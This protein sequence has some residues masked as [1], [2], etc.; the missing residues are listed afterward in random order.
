MG[1]LIDPHEVPKIEE[2][3]NDS[4]ATYHLQ[5]NLIL[6][7]QSGLSVRQVAA[8]VGISPSGVQY[9]VNRY[10]RLRL[11]AFIDSKLETNDKEITLVDE[12]N[13]IQPE[14]KT[15]NTPE[16]KRRPS[17]TKS[18]A[19]QEIRAKKQELVLPKKLDNPGLKPG[20]TMA[21]AGKKTLLYHFLQMLNNEKGT[22]LGDDIEALHDMRVATRRMRAAFDVFEKEYDQKIIRSII[23]GLRQT[24]RAL[25]EVRDLD[26]FIEKAEKYLSAQPEDKMLG[27]DPLLKY[28]HDQR[29]LC[30][31]KM[32]QYLESTA[33]RNF[34]LEFTEFL[35]TEGL[36]IKDGDPKKKFSKNDPIPIPC[37]VQYQVPLL[38]YT[39][40][41]H[42]NAYEDL[43]QNAIITQLHALR[44]E[45]KRLR[46]SL[47]FF[48][49]VLGNEVSIVID[50]IKRMQDHLG[51]LNDADVACNLLSEILTNWENLHT[52]TLLAERPNPEHLVAYLAYRAE[53]RHR[54]L[55]TFPSVWS[56]FN[57][58]EVR[59]KLA[60]AIAAL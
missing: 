46:Y 7:I 34:L 33:Y 43:L 32:I 20:D 49:E 45:F 1:V 24:G 44:I 28:W 14:P 15:K 25:G 51:D 39:R 17:K 36:G 23:K 58:P 50:E 18:G 27:L 57:D 2:I 53:E 19:K 52:Q 30:R 60:L 5:A 3:A 29:G 38:V 59:R 11:N 41:A 40:L 12:S 4:K 54:L 56:R 55:V 26:V 37:L 22:I 13:H 6:L 8:R 35:T 9:W 10:R 48:K 42:V 31:E 16:E 21:E 47:E